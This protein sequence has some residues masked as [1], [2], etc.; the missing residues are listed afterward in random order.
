MLNYRAVLS[1]CLQLL[2]PC[3]QHDQIC[4]ERFPFILFRLRMDWRAPYIV[5]HQ[6]AQKE[7]G[8]KSSSHS[9]RKHTPTPV[10]DDRS[11]LLWD[12]ST[13]ICLPGNTTVVSQSTSVFCPRMVDWNPFMGQVSPE[14]AGTQFTLHS[15]EP[16]THT[17][18]SLGSVLQVRG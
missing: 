11:W 4:K 2:C 9:F 3:S 10:Y 16:T 12:I 8:I 6:T 1:A 5:Q 17:L 15:G 13:Y 18:S 7:V 14:I